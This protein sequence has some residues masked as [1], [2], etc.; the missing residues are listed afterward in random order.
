M[1][2][3][4]YAL[5]VCTL[6]AGCAKKQV[7]KSTT[8]KAAVVGAGDTRTITIE[9]LDND[10]YWLNENATD[11]KYAFTSANPVKVGKHN[12]SGP[13]NERRFL[14]ALLGPAGEP[15]GYFRSGSCCAFSTP[16]GLI[17]GNGLLDVYRVFLQGGKDTVNIYINMYDEGD[18]FIPVGFTAKK[19]Q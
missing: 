13:L 6:L 15:I 12:G 9:Y 5:L 18:L 10:T 1:T 3:F 17:G 7:S 11:A 4:F 19:S 8:K 14:N 16:N 2:R